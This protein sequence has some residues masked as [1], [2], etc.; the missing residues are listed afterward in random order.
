MGRAARLAVAALAA[1]A[2]A[3]PRAAASEE[4]GAGAASAPL[5]VERVGDDR[6]R[7]EARG[8]S[9]DALLEALARAA[10]FTVAVGAG[11]PA[12][13]TL[14]L[15]LP[16]VPVEEAL[17]AALEGVPYHLH[18]QAS[19]ADGTVALR[20]VTVGLLPPAPSA[21]PGPPAGE[22]AEHA[23]RRADREAAPAAEAARS[24][25]ER[26]ERLASLRDART[27]TEREEAA[28]LMRPDADLEAL[29]AYLRDPSARVRA[30]AA[31][32]LGAVELG[33]NAFRAT[34]GLLAALG[35]ADSAV[36]LAA[37]D[38]L[39]SVYDVL[40]DPRIRA[41]VA[42]LAGH[43]DPAVR[44]AAAAFREWTEEEP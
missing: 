3:G 6:L 39:E 17:A 29:L 13:R 27:D 14:S 38:A 30:R 34:D 4:A 35:D 43:R 21:P 32:S 26:R 24:E 8:V 1:F 2:A 41:G 23:R 40:P 36:V 5:V 22:S 25:D 31:A 11:R 44:D 9:R 16:D 18:Y 20:R 37:V 42:R 33:E 12:P 7:V 10:G 28:S 15:D 19:E